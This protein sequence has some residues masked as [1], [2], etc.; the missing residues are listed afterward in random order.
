MLSVP[1]EL[2]FRQ[3]VISGHHQRIRFKVFPGFAIDVILGKGRG[4]LLQLVVRVCDGDFWISDDSQGK[5]RDLFTEAA[6]F[7]DVHQII[8]P[9]VCIRRIVV[10][11]SLNRFSDTLV[12]VEYTLIIFLLI[13]NLLQL[14]SGSVVFRLLLKYI[15]D[16][17]L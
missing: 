17:L 2:L 10:A 3:E 1:K 8:H 11:E 15:Q 4:E 7:E 9:T 16:E 6:C 5:N 13:G 14:V 12:Q